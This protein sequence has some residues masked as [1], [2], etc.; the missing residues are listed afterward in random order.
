MSGKVRGR[1]NSHKAIICISFVF[2]LHQGD[3]LQSARFFQP[4]PRFR[5]LL[6]ST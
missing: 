5:L 2:L 4:K 1:I 6:N 3:M